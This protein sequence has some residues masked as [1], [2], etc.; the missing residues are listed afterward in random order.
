MSGYLKRKK[1]PPS[2]ATKTKMA[3]HNFHSKY[4]FNATEVVTPV[5]GAI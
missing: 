2:G 3:S 1:I 5:A 4:F